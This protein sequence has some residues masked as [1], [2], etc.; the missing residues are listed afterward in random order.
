MI[1]EPAVDGITLGKSSLHA[2]N[3]RTVEELQSLPALLQR[4]Y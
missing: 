1:L 4:W 3:E 2:G